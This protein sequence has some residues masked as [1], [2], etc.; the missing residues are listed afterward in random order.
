[1]FRTVVTWIRNR[2]WSGSG[3]IH[4]PLFELL[5]GAKCLETCLD[6]SEIKWREFGENYIIR[7]RII[8]SDREASGDEHVA[9]VPWLA[10]RDPK[11]A[12]EIFKG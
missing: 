10:H 6:A 1:M 4:C 7:S 3:S 12:H 9:Y 8:S 11:I 5:A 2:T